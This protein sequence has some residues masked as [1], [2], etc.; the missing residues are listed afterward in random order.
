MFCIL[1]C[2]VDLCY[3]VL[4]L[5]CMDYWMKMSFKVRK[6]RIAAFCARRGVL[7]SFVG[8]KLILVLCDV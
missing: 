7:K 8:L 6:L 5:L 3:I 4:M 1:D 2:V